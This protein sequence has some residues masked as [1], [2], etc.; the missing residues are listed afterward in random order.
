MS[1]RGKRASA[2]KWRGG[3]SGGMSKHRTS[4]RAPQFG[5]QEIARLMNEEATR[6]PRA[7]RMFASMAA[8]MRSRRGP[9]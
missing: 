7:Y 5:T 2:R 6:R 8:L 9:V 1:K 4:G 3:T